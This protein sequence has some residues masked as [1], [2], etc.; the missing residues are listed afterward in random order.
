MVHIV[1]L[2]LLAPMEYSAKPIPYGTDDISITGIHWLPSKTITP[3]RVRLVHVRD[4][5]LKAGRE[6]ERYSPMSSR[7]LGV[8]V[9][10]IVWVRI[11]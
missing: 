4:D 10:G 6:E 5:L 8:M 3:R 1:S 11:L 9:S 7:F 2:D